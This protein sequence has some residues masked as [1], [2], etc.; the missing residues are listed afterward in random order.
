M[1]REHS[2]RGPS[3]KHFK[4]SHDRGA[5][6]TVS[7]LERAHHIFFEHLWHMALSDRL[8]VGCGP[9]T[10]GRVSRVSGCGKEAARLLRPCR[11]WLQIVKNALTVERRFCRRCENLD[12]A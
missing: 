1:P 6:L 2:R 9:H 4:L 3:I 11:G 8:E 5:T 12:T 10:I 7:L